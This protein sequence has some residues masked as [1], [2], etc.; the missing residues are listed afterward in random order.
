MLFAH[1]DRLIFVITNEQNKFHVHNKQYKQRPIGSWASDLWS[2]VKCAKRKQQQKIIGMSG[3]TN[4]STGKKAQ[5]AI[6]SYN[7]CRR[8]LFLMLLLLL[9][10]ER[11]KKEEKNETTPKVIIGLTGI[12]IV[13][14]D[15]KTHKFVFKKT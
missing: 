6:C 11:I 5:S 15:H 10:F 14:L 1:Y 4:N 7:I 8:W 3:Q 9:L 13:V 2:S 12:V